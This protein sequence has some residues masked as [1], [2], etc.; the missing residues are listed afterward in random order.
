[1]TGVLETAARQARAADEVAHRPWPLPEGPWVQAHTRHD[2]LLAFW[3]LSVAAVGRRVPPE[4]AV[5]T[6]EG[7]A[8][9]GIAAY[10]VEALRLRGLPPVPGLA[11]FPQVEV[12]AC[13]T[14]DDRPGL[15][16][17]SLEVPK[18][19]LVE[20]AKRVHRLPAYRASVAAGPGAYDVERDGLSL[21]VRYGPLGEPRVPEPGTLEHF[22][23][24]RYALYT[25][26]GGRL[27]RAQLH[28][29]P[30]RLA[31]AEATVDEAT[32]LPYELEGSP[33]AFLATE[34][35]VLVWPLE[36]L[37][38]VGSTEPP[39][40]AASREAAFPTPERGGEA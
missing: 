38:G 13:V 27:Y 39:D 9:A 14:A 5:D 26:D 35:D 3:P 23:A 11:S 15:W 24:E 10:R 29:P 22:L 36:E 28:H 30:S 19:V 25:A 21:R 6:W 7:Q 32:L 17:D 34:Q 37:S 40:N 2:G 31:P 1:V 12:V 8:W 33:R 4:L 20:A 18:G 16:V